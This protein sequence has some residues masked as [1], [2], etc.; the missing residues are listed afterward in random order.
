MIVVTHEMDFARSVGDTLVMIDGG[1]VIERGPCAEVI[2]APRMERTAAFLS[3]VR[4][5]PPATGSFVAGEAGAG[6]DRDVK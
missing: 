5:E 2:D 3:T 1:V 6:L 4:R